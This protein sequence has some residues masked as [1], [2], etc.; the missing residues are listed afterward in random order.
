M[1]NRRRALEAPLGLWRRVLEL[2]GCTVHFARALSAHRLAD[3]VPR[4]LRRELRDAT[5]VSLHRAILVHRQIGEIADVAASHGIRVLALKGAARLLAGEPA[6]SRS[7]GDID[8]LVRSADGARFH[9]LLQRKLGYA[10]AGSEYPHHLQGLTRHASLGVEVHVR[11]S[12]T[13]L[14]LDADIWRDTRHVSLGTR[15]IEIPSPT[16]MILH[17]LEHAIGLNWA[18]RYRLRDIAD[19][20]SL[21]TEGEVAPAV[22]DYVRSRPDRRAFET[23]LSAANEIEPRAPRA[24][25]R[26]WRTVCRVSRARI[27]LAVLPRTGRIAERWYRY[28]GI[29]AE[30]SLKIL[31]RA[32]FGLVRRLAA[33]AV[34]IV[35]LV[36]AGCSDSTRPN[37]DDVPP[38]VF[39]SNA[40]GL[41]GI[42]RFDRGQIVRLSS[43]PHEDG[44]PHSAA[45][46]IVFT[47]WRDGDAEIY[48]A[49]LELREQLRLTDD[50]SVD[51]EPALDPSG[52]TVA[53]VS[54]R[55]GTP[56]IWL[57]DADGDNPRPLDMGSPT[58]V[59]EG[60]PAWSPSG[61]RIAFM[62]T[63]TNTA[64][65]FIG[66]AAGGAVRQLSHEAGGAF[67]PLWRADGNAV[68]YTA[69]AGGPR[70]MTVS[71]D[72]G[73]A[74]L[75]ASAGD[76]LGDG[77]C[78]VGLCVAVSRLL[79][80]D[81][82]LVTVTEGDGVP[83]ALLV[84]PADDREPAFLVP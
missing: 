8:L 3:D 59:P 54:N 50:A 1:S 80:A 63:R 61:D 10:V 67:A 47:S 64:Q 30:G 74:S 53:F 34:A 25:A 17:A 7:I 48:I 16:S 22:V 45:G 11:L 75:F 60:S 19:V 65:V 39:V 68:V 83:R 56:R 78:T 73:D 81:G 36:G 27:A 70:L 49:D 5:G 46:R 43:A 24:R 77:A 26:A 66:D 2:E 72:G 51:T 33:G 29:V 4:R 84:R 6:G 52:T 13:P 12:N 18:G 32:G 21:F 79:G 76:G 14:A 15:T 71:V 69:L 82:D 35:V 58:H 55:S 41:P 31:V 20:A 23:L 57:M 9:Q 40:D 37:A 44:E 28:A 42:F 38:F 62:S